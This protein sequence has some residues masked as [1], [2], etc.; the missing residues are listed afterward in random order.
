MVTAYDLYNLHCL[1]LKKIVML[2]CYLNESTIAVWLKFTQTY[3]KA[4][5]EEFMENV[6]KGIQ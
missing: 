2:L 6:R 1:I 5:C 3:I 4:I